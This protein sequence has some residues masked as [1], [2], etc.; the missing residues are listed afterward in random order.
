[1]SER[2]VTVESTI[3][4]SKAPRTPR[5]WTGT[6]TDTKFVAS[7][8][9]N[10]IIQIAIFKNDCDWAPASF[11]SQVC[12]GVKNIR[13]GSNALKMGIMYFIFV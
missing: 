13:R 5:I 8:I 10:I 3:I 11:S 4:I 12:P 2:C 6:A 9:A 1:M 7:M